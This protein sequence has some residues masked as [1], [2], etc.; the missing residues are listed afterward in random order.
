MDL[1]SDEFGKH[2]QAVVEQEP[3]ATVRP[4][5]VHKPGELIVAGKDDA[6]ADDQDKDPMQQKVP[7][8]CLCVLGPLDLLL[9]LDKAIA[10]QCSRDEDGEDT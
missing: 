2:N 5:V 3:L 9:N 10:E 8:L 1:T 6:D 7:C 4:V